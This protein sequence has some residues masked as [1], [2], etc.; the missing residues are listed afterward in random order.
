MNRI[1]GAFSTHFCDHPVT[2]YEEACRSDGEQFAVFFR[3]ML[4]RGI[5][6]APSR[7]EAWFL[8]IA[9]SRDDVEQTVEAAE[10]ALRSVAKT[11]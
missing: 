6:L 1:R 8:T 11:L 3:E 9:H 2:C 4:D 10:Q 5:L 7:F